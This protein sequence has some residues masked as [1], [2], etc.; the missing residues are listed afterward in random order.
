MPTVDVS[1]RLPQ[2]TSERGWDGARCEIKTPA[3]DQEI[4][5]ELMLLGT[6]V[7]GETFADR[8][9]G[10]HKPNLRVSWALLSVLL[11]THI[12]SSSAE[13]PAFIAQV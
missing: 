8:T 3:S 4:S 6:Q 1:H 12:L 5:P 13:S 9:S 10:S 2:G 11:N 7:A